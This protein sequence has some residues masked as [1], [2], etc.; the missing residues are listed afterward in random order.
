M[1]ELLP[2]SPAVHKTA[3]PA[4]SMGSSMARHAATTKS[5]AEMKTGLVDNALWSGSRALCEAGRH[6]C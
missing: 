1:L 5:E 3:L 2:K 4:V 6:T